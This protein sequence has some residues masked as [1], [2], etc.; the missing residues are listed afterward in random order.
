MHPGNVALEHAMNNNVM[1]GQ[2]ACAPA[3]AGCGS[4]SVAT[5]LTA[6]SGHRCVIITEHNVCFSFVRLAF[7]LLVMV[8]VPLT[9]TNLSWYS[10]VGTFPNWD[11]TDKWQLTNTA[12]YLQC[13]YEP[14]RSAEMRSGLATLSRKS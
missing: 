1:D 10:S 2:A 3:T 8:L 4:Q 12:P 6:F 9:L 7:S 11:P 14:W 5:L 13:G